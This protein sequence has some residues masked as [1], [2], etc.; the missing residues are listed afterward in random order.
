MRLAAI[1]PL[2]VAASCVLVEDDAP[3]LGRVESAVTYVT[4]GS[5]T[6][7]ATAN[8][9]TNTTSFHLGTIA[10]GRTLKIGTCGVSGSGFFGDTYLRLYHDVGGAWIEVEADDQA[11]GGNGSL[12]VY[13][14]PFDSALQVR[15]GCFSS[16]SC[17]GAIAY[18]MQFDAHP[19][20]QD[21]VTAIAGSSFDTTGTLMGIDDPNGMLAGVSSPNTY[22]F[23]GFARF[24]DRTNWDFAISAAVSSGS[25]TL[26]FGK[27]GSDP[28]VTAST[29]FGANSPPPNINVN[30]RVHVG[31]QI[32][33]VSTLNHGG[34]VQA[35]GD[36]LFAAAEAVGAGGG[37]GQVERILAN[38]PT[39]LEQG[40]P[41]SRSSNGAAWV[42]I[43]K[44]G[45]GTNTPSALR[46]GYFIM[47]G[48]QD[49]EENSMFAILPN[50]DGWAN[51][52]GAWTARGCWK[53]SSGG[54]ASC[55]SI[56]KQSAIGGDVSMDDYQN[57]NLITQ[58]DGTVYMVAYSD[59]ANAWVDVWQIYWGTP[60]GLTQ[61]L[62]NGASCT[63]S[64][65]CMVKV[66]KRQMTL[67]SGNITP[68]SFDKGVG[69][70]V[71]AGSPWISG[72]DQFF[73]YSTDNDVCNGSS[74]NDGGPNH[75]YTKI[76]EF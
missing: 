66:A 15:G 9:T 59:G 6:A 26:W 39:P 8:A 63:N 49:T 67:S 14:V 20:P 16:T 32:G 45:K 64:H 27:F 19:Q 46:R 54:G 69:G 47:V 1:V 60:S 5:Y 44:L 50:A 7:S 12:I 2:L 25:N 73:V 62:P 71:V 4:V 30:D 13:T 57:V 76:N 74:C 40:V 34:G 41:L 11:C 10:A 42:A 24:G 31:L 53:R 68:E 29:R 28:N 52:E 65:V 56:V 58:S 70:Y 36:Y 33:N 75:F 37:T 35:I 43:T 23:E 61:T 72:D 3:D 18:E 38:L 22:H 51:I 17:Q 48:G 21:L 55:P